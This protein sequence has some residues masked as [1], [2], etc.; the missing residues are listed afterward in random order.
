LLASNLWIGLSVLFLRTAPL[1]ARTF[2]V[3]EVVSLVVLDLL[4]VVALRFIGYTPAADIYWSGAL[5]VAAP[6]PF[7]LAT[8]HL[9]T[10]S[11]GA[12]ARRVAL[13]L[14]VGFYGALPLVL[15][16]I[17]L[18][19][20]MQRHF[21][22]LPGA[23]ELAAGTWLIAVVARLVQ[24]VGHPAGVVRIFACAAVF[25][26]TWV[27]PMFAVGRTLV[28][29]TPSRDYDDYVAQRRH[30]ELVFEEADRAQAAEAMLAA[31]RPGVTD[32]Y[33][34]G[35]AGW[36][37][38]DVFGNEVRSARRLFD[39]RFDTDGR[40]IILSN[41]SARDGVL[42]LTSSPTLRHVLGAVGKRM[43]RD[44]DVLF[45]FIS[46]HGSR[47]GLAL[48]PP[49]G[50]AFESETLRPESLRSMLDAAGI[51]WRVLVV[52]GCESGVFLDSLRNEFTLIATAAASDR[53]SYGCAMGNPFT[54]FGRAVFEEQLVRERS[55]F[56][57]FTNA[58][59]VI[60][61]REVDAKVRTSRP[62]IAE[63]SSIRAKLREL[64][65]GLAARSAK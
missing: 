21:E 13:R 7:F 24:S 56:T 42:P 18:S 17:F 61:K 57:A 20:R 6:I 33:F 50:A 63:G 16:A 35:A 26:A 64:E 5:A 41:E 52:S 23:L 48:L 34:V 29:Y 8:A 14:L 51:K 65:Q 27:I 53:Y 10:R 54:N 9:A 49:P 36:A 30:D 12:D 59:K 4:V 46:S 40:S 37:N 1:R 58:A 15:G 38:Q 25:A 19:I 2:T 62:Q 47:E 45:L 31:E 44:E 28:T 60:D 3:D 55:F 43:D 22:P 32:L 11:R 39:E